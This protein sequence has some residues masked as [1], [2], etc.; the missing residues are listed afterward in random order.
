MAKVNPNNKNETKSDIFPWD[1]FKSDVIY[2][3]YQNNIKYFN[4]FQNQNFSVL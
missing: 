4:D 3:F 1:I 2:F